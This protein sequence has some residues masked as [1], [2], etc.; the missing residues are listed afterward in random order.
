MTSVDRRAWALSVAMAVG[1]CGGGPA[2]DTATGSASSM[3]E[4]DPASG[5]VPTAHNVLTA[6]EVAEGWR[7]LFD[8][9]TTTGWRAY[10]G[11]SF[12][13]TG[14]AVVDGTL[15]VGATAQDPDV[16]IGETS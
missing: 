15:V 8:G 5:G 13:D 6:E 9:E 7:L 2:D 14:W 12:P 10:N 1:A 16:P 3:A 11:D 4:A